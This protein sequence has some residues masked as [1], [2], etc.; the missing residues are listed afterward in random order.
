M[1]FLTHDEIFPP[2]YLSRIPLKLLRVSRTHTYGKRSR[3]RDISKDPR[4][5][6]TPIKIFWYLH[7]WYFIQNLKYMLSCS[8]STF[9]MVVLLG[10]VVRRVVGAE[11]NSST[12]GIPCW[13]RWILWRVRFPRLTIFENEFNSISTSILSRNILAMF[14]YLL[15][16]VPR[17]LVSSQCIAQVWRRTEPTCSGHDM[18]SLQLWMTRLGYLYPECHKSV[19]YYNSIQYS[20]NGF[21]PHLFIY[22]L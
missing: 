6:F 9:V 3:L 12:V 5:V 21:W 17:D 1:W 4:G 10:T 14:A 8:P 2:K 16:L 22:L 11:I 7:G 20:P 15:D 19:E 13:I 18:T